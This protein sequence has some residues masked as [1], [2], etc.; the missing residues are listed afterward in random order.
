MAPAPSL[1]YCSRNFFRDA[2]LVQSSSSQQHRTSSGAMPSEG[3]FRSRLYVKWS[4]TSS[5]SVAIVRVLSCRS[6]LLTSPHPAPSST[7]RRP[8]HHS[9]GTCSAA[10]LERDT[11]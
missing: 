5:K 9:L 11:E 2:T 1:Q 4:R 3:Q 6:V 10:N 7:Q 8:C